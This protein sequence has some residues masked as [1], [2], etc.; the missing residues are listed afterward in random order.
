MKRNGGEVIR[1]YTLK[2][3]A[4]KLKIGANT[5]KRACEEGHIKATWCITESALEEALHNGIDFRELA[6][7]STRKKRAT[8]KALK[9][10]QEICVVIQNHINSKLGKK[11]RMSKDLRDYLVTAELWKRYLDSSI[12]VQEL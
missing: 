12:G 6:K 8:A 2:E 11:R 9:E 7:L 10:Y 4:L 1:T 3:A 5:L